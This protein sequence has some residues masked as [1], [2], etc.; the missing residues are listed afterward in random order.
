MVPEHFRFLGGLGVDLQ[1]PSGESG[2]LTWVPQGQ[3]VG[4]ARWGSRSRP[5]GPQVVKGRPIGLLGLKSSVGRPRGSH[6]Q[7]SIF[8]IH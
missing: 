8:S 2:R 6:S 3:I 1:G 4:L 7:P 5:T